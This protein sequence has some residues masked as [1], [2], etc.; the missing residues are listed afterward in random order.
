MKN[1]FS[2][3]LIIGAFC[4][5]QIVKGTDISKLSPEDRHE[6]LSS[7]D[8]KEKHQLLLKYREDMQVEKLK[9][10]AEKEETFR[11]I[12]RAYHKELGEIKNGF[13][14]KFDID[15]LTEKEA[16]EKL[17]K[18]FSI[19]EKYIECRRKYTKEFLKIISPQQI[20]KMFRI[21]GMMKEKMMKK[22]ENNKPKED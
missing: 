2:I 6:R 12:Y 8:P 22:H 3:F 14:P 16:L 11:Q 17:E 5:A 4:Q 18:S 7:L 13:N 10:S 9:I 19:G 15:N 21:E 20:L 1:L